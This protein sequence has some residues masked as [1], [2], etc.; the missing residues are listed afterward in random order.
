[1]GQAHEGKRRSSKEVVLKKIRGIRTAK[2]LP[3]VPSFQAEIGPLNDRNAYVQISVRGVK[4]KNV[5]LDGGSTVNLMSE[6]TYQRLHN[7][8]LML[9]SFH[10]IMVDQWACHRTNSTNSHG[11]VFLAQL[12]VGWK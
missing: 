2:N 4:L 7:V 12:K 9:V 10:L 6:K 3:G 5:L 8:K 1:M 11:G